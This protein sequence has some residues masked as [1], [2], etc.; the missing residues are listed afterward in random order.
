[1][2]DLP[3]APPTPLAPHR[4]LRCSSRLTLTACLPCALVLA[5]HRHQLLCT[6]I[7]PYRTQKTLRGPFDLTRIVTKTQCL[8][9]H[10]S[11]SR[12][13][14]FCTSSPPRS[15]EICLLSLSNH[16]TQNRTQPDSF[17]STSLVLQLSSPKPRLHTPTLSRGISAASIV[18]TSV[19]AAGQHTTFAYRSEYSPF[20][21]CAMYRT[22]SV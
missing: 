9:N 22:G 20:P 1:M 10:T 8:R 21:V 17:G 18:R 5:G 16:T 6:G 2:Q 13:R 3:Q 11:H 19:S 14:H 4:T 7:S 12:P 15:L